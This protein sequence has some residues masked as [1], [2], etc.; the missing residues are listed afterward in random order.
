MT[1]NPKLVCAGCEEE[2]EAIKQS[3]CQSC[4]STI[5]PC[6][7]GDICAKCGAFCGLPVNWG[8]QPDPSSE[9]SAMR[10]VC[11]AAE[12]MRADFPS[13]E[14][15]SVEQIGLDKALE[16]LKKARQGEAS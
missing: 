13:G 14:V 11:E 8:T 9:I 2:F 1:F 6:C 5:G 10:K 16:A 3:I 7:W 15:W 4:D 12:N